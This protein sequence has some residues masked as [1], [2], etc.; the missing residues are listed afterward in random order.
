MSYKISFLSLILLLIS[1]TSLPFDRGSLATSGKPVE[2]TPA[3]DRTAVIAFAKQYLGITYRR[4]GMDPRKGF[5]CSGFVGFV[6][7]E[8]DVR[9]PRSSSEY[10]AL[11]PALKPEDFKVG[12]VVVFYGFKDRGHIGHVGII[13]EA[14]GMKSKF[15]HA[16]S[17]KAHSVTISDLGSAGYTHRF[18]K[19][20]NVMG[21]RK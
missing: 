1:L 9:L 16:S 14:N 17:G 2:V 18:Y 12:D 8:F 4:A 21:L 19:V 11:G 5:D 10:N 3:L 7:R 6:F 20:I 15:I 13:C